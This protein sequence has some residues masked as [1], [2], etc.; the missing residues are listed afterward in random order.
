MN[1]DLY[2]RV[3]EKFGEN[4]S[5]LLES[6]TLTKTFFGGMPQSSNHFEW[7]RNEGR[8]LGFVGQLELTEFELGKS[9]PWLNFEGRIL[10]FYD[11]ERFPWGDSPDDNQGWVVIHETGEPEYLIPFPDDLNDFYRMPQ[12]KF[13]RGRN[14]ISLP[15]IQRLKYSGFSLDDNEWEDYRDLMEEYEGDSPRH[16]IGGYPS[17]IQDDT[18]EDICQLVSAGFDF[19]DSESTADSRVGEKKNELN[20]WKLL[21]QVDSDDDLE[22]MWGDSGRLYSWIRERDAE[23][24]DFSKVWMQIQSC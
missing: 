21:L 10:L 19:T 8:P 24:G 23:A 3:A 1:Q 18:M 11:M 2:H 16:Q 6:D 4:A 15:S 9:A 14:F 13:L 7:P 22:M 20:D 17:P 5:L 12:R